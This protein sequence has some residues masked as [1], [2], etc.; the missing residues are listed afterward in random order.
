MSDEAML[1]DPDL[2]VAAYRQGYFPMGDPE[3]DSIRWF[4]PDP[5][6]IIPIE[7]FRQ[8]RSLRRIIARGEFHVRVDTAFDEVIRACAA[9]EETWITPE[10]IRAYGVLHQRGVA[11]SVETWSESTLTGGLYGLALGGAFFG[12]SMFSRRS[13][14]SKVALVMLVRMLRAGGFGLLDVQFLNEH[15]LQFGAVEISRERYLAMLGDALKRDCPFVLP[16]DVR[17]PV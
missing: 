6:G 7:G 1:L 11:H 16:L 5:R 9:R 2:L 12:E 4:S 17:T 8:P 10:I 14:A 13:G 15:L 3:T